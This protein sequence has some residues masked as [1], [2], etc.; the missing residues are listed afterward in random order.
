[1]GVHCNYRL[2]VNYR[3]DHIGCLAADSRKSL[4]LLDLRRHYATEIRNQLASHADQMLG[5]VVRERD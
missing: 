4:Q 5:L 3:R 2:V 1:M